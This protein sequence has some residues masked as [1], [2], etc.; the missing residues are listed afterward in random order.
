MNRL[1]KELGEI[2]EEFRQESE[3]DVPGIIRARTYARDVLKTLRKHLQKEQI[4]ENQGFWAAVGGFGRGDLSF[5]SDLDLL[6]VYKK[7]L[8]PEMQER[9]EALVQGLWD[10]GFEVGHTVCDLSRLKQLMESDFSVRTTYLETRFI[11]GSQ[12]L[13]DSWCAA[14]LKGN[15]AKTRKRDFLQ[16]LNTYRQS[17]VKRYA[18]SIYILEPHIK[19]SLG[20]LRDVHALRW[21]GAVFSGSPEPESLLHQGWI[22]FLEHHWLEQ[23]H[24]FLWRVRLQLHALLGRRKDQLL[25]QDQRELASRLGFL[26]A[27]QG[28]AAVEVFMRRYYRQTARIRRVTDFLLEQ[29]TEEVGPSRKQRRPKI[30]EGPFVLE[31]EHIH[32]HDPELVH[33]DPKI[34]MRIFWQA[35]QSGAHF[36]HGSGQVIRAN[37]EVFD[38]KL[39]AD[40]ELATLFFEIILNPRM[41]YRVLKAMLETGFLETYLPEFSEVRYRVQYDLYHVYTVDE[42]LLK[43]LQELHLLT[44]P[45]HDPGPAPGSPD[46][47]QL[48]A[49]LEHKRVLILGGLVHD[50]GKGHGQGHAARGARMVVPLARRLHLSDTE[51]EL[52]RSLVENHLLL[53]E[54]AL[55][56][57]L[58]DEKPIER[59]ALKIGSL[60]LLSMLYLLTVADSKATGPQVWSSWRRSLL[61]EL[62]GKVEKLLS[63]KPWQESEVTSRIAACRAYLRQHLAE[64]LELQKVLSW[65]DGLS[66]RYLLAREPKELYHHY[67]LEKKLEKQ[68]LVLDVRP[69]SGQMWEATFICHDRPLLFDLLT[70]VLWAY[71]VNILS[72][73][74]YTRGYGVAVDILIVDQ[75]P[76]PLHPEKLWENISRDLS[77]VLTGERDLEKLLQKSRPDRIGRIRPV[78]VKEDK[79]VIDEQ[80]SDFYTVIEVYTWERTGVL[81]AI[82]KVL[83][84]F[85]LSIQLAKISTPGAQV[86]DV[87]YVTALDGTKIWDKTIQVRLEKALLKALKS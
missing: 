48:F 34:L 74:I 60:E 7:Q 55:K 80:A 85:D 21:I 1:C 53:A 57:D 31:G 42:H 26:D 82:S 67:Q 44:Q 24:D 59:C 61:N 23:A 62:F 36:H 77:L 11:S 84:Q 72:A 65:L 14:L 16:A 43:T 71:G 63:N 83:H 13:Y 41:A 79:V 20:G 50:L 18:E 17:R 29:L 47:R 27:D 30:L 28:I 56:R 58:F 32:F 35:S 15:R 9:I 68:T 70:G 66:Y 6:F 54:T 2:R 81:H 8:T 25:L 86:V 73:D 76:D 5:A 33:S 75:I 37:L 45:E 49:A 19:E 51:T 4:A 52:L 38:Q 12:K 64:P 69:L 46:P 87:F 22:T 39:R 10:M 78:V 40:G 3:Q